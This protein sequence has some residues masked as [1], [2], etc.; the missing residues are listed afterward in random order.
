MTVAMVL[1]V[2][3]NEQEAWCQL[4][5]V[6][7]HGA[8]S[9]SLPELLSNLKVTPIVCNPSPPGKV[10]SKVQSEHGRWVSVRKEAPAAGMHL[11]CRMIPPLPC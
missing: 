9:N 3:V 8:I 5:R 11:L 4:S 1:Q 6:L 7:E 2:A 10:E